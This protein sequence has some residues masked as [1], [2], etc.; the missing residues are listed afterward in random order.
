MGLPEKNMVHL[1]FCREMAKFIDL[2]HNQN[3]ENARNKR[4]ILST[5]NRILLTA[6]LPWTCDILLKLFKEFVEKYNLLIHIILWKTWFLFL[7]ISEKGGELT[8]FLFNSTVMF[9]IFWDFLMVEQIFLSPQLKGSV[10]I[11]NKLVYINC[12]T[13]SE[14]LKTLEIWKYQEYLKTS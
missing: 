7:K 14:Q 1:L 10:I 9:I 4:S 8:K 2:Q 11:S 3:D 5:L 13:S 6:I 12:L